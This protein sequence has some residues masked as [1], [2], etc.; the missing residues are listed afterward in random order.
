MSSDLF[1]AEDPKGIS[2][3]LEMNVH[4]TLFLTALGKEERDHGERGEEMVTFTFHPDERGIGQARKMRDALD[5]W[6]RHAGGVEIQTNMP[7]KLK[8]LLDALYEWRD[9]LPALPGDKSDGV[10]GALIHATDEWRSVG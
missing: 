8:A 5:N 1:D 10:A 2:I 6:A 4:N 9:S 7:P 3:D